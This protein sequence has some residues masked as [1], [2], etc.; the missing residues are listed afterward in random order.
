MSME[1]NCTNGCH[2]RLSLSELRR[3]KIQT[4]MTERDYEQEMIK[5]RGKLYRQSNPYCR[6]C[7]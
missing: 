2:S 7:D 3:K 1:K 5:V 4:K 6:N